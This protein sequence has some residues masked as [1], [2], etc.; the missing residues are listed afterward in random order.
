MIVLLPGEKPGFSKKPGFCRAEN[1]LPQ[2]PCPAAQALLPSYQHGRGGERMAMHRSAAEELDPRTRELYR[3]ALWALSKAGVPFLV[4]GAYALAEFT[5]V[6]RHT[7]DLDVF[8]RPADVG[9]ALDALCAAGYRTELTF[10]H[11]LGKAYRGDD[12]LDV[13]FSSGNGLVT[14]DDGWFEHSVPAEVV[15][16]PV[17]LCPVEETIC[18]KAFVMERERYDGA[19]IAHLIR[20]RAREMDWPRLLRRFG[21]HWRVLLGCLV[22][23]AFIYP[24]ERSLVPAWVMDEL[25]ARLREETLSPPPAGRVCQGTLLSREQ[26]LIDIEQWG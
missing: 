17:W 15:G 8:V 13:I 12:F 26:F 18:S 21:P 3:H 10:T 6:V 4:G 11:W 1:S 2:T 25:T 23:F 14:V 16:L 5:G 24:S 9:H 19:D 22:L 20:A 7:K